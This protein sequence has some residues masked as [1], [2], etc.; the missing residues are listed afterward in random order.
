MD[1]SKSQQ[2]S[3][4][5]GRSRGRGRGSRSHPV[6]P[7][8]QSQPRGQEAY[9]PRPPPQAYYPQP[10]PQA[11]YPAPPPLNPSHYNIAMTSEFNP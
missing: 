4:S 9:Y 8:V 3:T 10:P 5:K 6:R 1:P 2:G 11:Y 7:K